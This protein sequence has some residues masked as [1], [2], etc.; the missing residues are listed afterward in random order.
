MLY[1]ML[2]GE[3]PFNGRTPTEIALKQIQAEPKSPRALNPDL[4]ASLEKC[5]L[6]ALK[7]NPIERQQSVGE[8]AAELRAGVNQ[9]VIPLQHTLEEEEETVSSNLVL[10]SEANVLFESDEQL[11]LTQ[12]RR[13]F[14][15]VAA[16]S[17]FLIFSTA[18]LLLARHLNGSGRAP[19]A[20]PGN[21]AATA[22][23]SP[24][25]TTSQNSANGVS[26]PLSDADALEL[27]ARGSQGYVPIVSPSHTPPVKTQAIE[28]N[29]VHTRPAV[30]SH[31]KGKEQKRPIVARTDFPPPPSAKPQ[32][33]P[34]PSPAITAN[35]VPQPTS[36][37]DIAQA[38]R[39][40]DENSVRK[41]EPNDNID[42]RRPQ[43]DRPGARGPRRD[44]ELE[45]KRRGPVDS[46]RDDHSDDDSD[47]D[48]EQDRSDRDRKE[49]QKKDKDKRDDERRDDD[50]RDD[51]EEWDRIGPKLITW[52]GSVDEERVI[53]I[54]MPGVPGT[55]EIPRVYRYRVGVVEPPSHSNRWRCAVLRV[56]GRGS[57]SILVR[58]WPMAR[59]SIKLTARR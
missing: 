14:T 6:R 46:D 13:R 37:P 26:S 7:K 58:W 17:L 31:S 15:A 45:A 21:I 1:E 59:G 41:S 56:F 20:D 3:R 55:I 54:E 18:G 34:A 32:S 2:T 16:V 35:R 23:S 47:D 10:A 24:A 52:R 51:D 49:R 19:S 25:A 40:R 9:I 8:F 57:V 33:P 44:R 11:N 43:Y 42:N 39:R 22:S 30:K 4:S 12:G 27:A 38:P 29:T 28:T 5:L 48:S 36:E 53:K 50:R